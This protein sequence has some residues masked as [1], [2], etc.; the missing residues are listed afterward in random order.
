MDTTAGRNFICRLVVLAA[1]GAVLGIWVALDWPCLIRSLTGVPCPSCGMSRAWLAAFRL[2]FAQAFRM[3]PLFWS[4]PVLAALWLYP[5]KRYP[6]WAVVVCLCI[7]IG[8]VVCYV[9][10]LWAYFTGAGVV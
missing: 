9:I 6:K 8:Y 3:H 1:M 2:D 5:W 7:A 10:R 4:V